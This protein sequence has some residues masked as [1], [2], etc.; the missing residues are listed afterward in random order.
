LI[1]IPLKYM[2][3]TVET[4]HKE[5]V[6]NCINL[7]YEFLVQLPKNHDFRYFKV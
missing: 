6:E 2:H 3:T 1:S 5:D 4:A 7:M